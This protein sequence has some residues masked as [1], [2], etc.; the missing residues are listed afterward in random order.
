MYLL[1]ECNYVYMYRLLSIVYS[2]G[3][4]VVLLCRMQVFVCVCTWSPAPISSSAL[5]ICTPL[6]ICG[7]CCSIATK[8]FKLRQ[9]KPDNWRLFLFYF[10]SRSIWNM[11]RLFSLY[12]QTLRTIQILH[13]CEN[14]KWTICCKIFCMIVEKSLIL[15]WNVYPHIHRW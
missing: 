10:F 13:N 11:K 3:C 8:R 2:I 6:A 1:K 12:S 5:L 15:L 14:I 4:V 7:D 9:S